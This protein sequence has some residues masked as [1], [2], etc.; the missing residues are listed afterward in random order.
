MATNIK[1]KKKKGSYDNKLILWIS[2]GLGALVAII[3]AIAI[4]VSLSNNYVAKVNGKKVYTYEY[5]WFLRQAVS[6]EYQENFDEFKPENYDDMTEDEKNTV[7]NNFFDTERRAKC[8]ADAL[9]KAREF[10][11]ES[12]LA[13]QKG[14]A[15][16]SKER[17]TLKSNIDAYLNMYMQYGYS[18]DA[19][20]YAMTQ[21][22]MSLS[23]YKKFT[24]T[25]TSVERYKQSLKDSYEISDDELKTKYDEDPNEYRTVNGRVFQFS[26]PKLPSEPK[27]AEGKVITKEDAEKADA[28]TADK[29]A[30]EKYEKDL[31][32]YN[33]KIANYIVLAGMMKEAYD[34]GAD[35]KFTYY[36]YDMTTLTP[37]KKEAKEGE[38]APAEDEDAVLEKDATFELLC[39]SQSSFTLNGS[40]ASTTKGVVN[41]NNNTSSGVEDIDKFLLRAQWNS[42]RDGF[43]FDPAE[44]AEESTSGTSSE[45][46]TTGTAEEAKINPSEIEI[47]QVKDDDGNLTALYLVRAENISDLDSEAD[48]NEDGLNATKRTV[49]AEVLEDKATADMKAEVEAGGS[50]FALKSVKRKQL[51]KSMKEVMG[52]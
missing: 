2:V 48:G 1:A 14:F 6:E 19:A 17:G 13:K 39:T 47:I 11:A 7:F 42:S 28:A 20:V 37:K 35:A 15:L 30:Y 22:A 12:I 8:E 24:V 18:Y 27:N 38:E 51:D 16:N 26:I 46:E 23:D 10:K 31:E 33:K 5:N 49:K 36:D 44:D 45:A 43:V 29:L 41:V 50:K 21:G 25:Q 40:A 4:I 52:D 3:A 32:E 34:K 9:E